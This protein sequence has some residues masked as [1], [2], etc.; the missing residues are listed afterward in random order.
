LR[1]LADWI[2]ALYLV[3]IPIGT[4]PSF[5]HYASTRANVTERKPEI[6]LTRILN[7]EKKALAVSIIFAW[8]EF[9]RAQR[10]LCG[11]RV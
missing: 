5:E 2:P 4:E 10:E 8:K 1:L 7:K 6:V 11:L 3:D 9:S